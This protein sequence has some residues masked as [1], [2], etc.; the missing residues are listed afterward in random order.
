MVSDIGAAMH[1]RGVI[2]FQYLD[3]WLII[4]PDKEIIQQQLTELLEL[5]TSLGLMVNWGKSDLTPSKQFVYLG[6]HF[7]LTAGLIRTTG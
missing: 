4:H 1:L 2:M 7:D 3:D 5:T 6:V